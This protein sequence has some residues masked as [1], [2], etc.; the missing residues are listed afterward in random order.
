MARP[1]SS[2][3]AQGVP[4]GSTASS[5]GMEAAVTKYD[6]VITHFFENASE[7]PPMSN[8][9]AMLD[10]RIR[11]DAVRQTE[12]RSAWLVNPWSAKANFMW[13]FTAPMEEMEHALPISNS[14]NE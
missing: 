8:R 2:E 3:K 10:H 13:K 7:N 5:S 12:F 4:G 11:T 1:N 14:Q 6:A 9:P